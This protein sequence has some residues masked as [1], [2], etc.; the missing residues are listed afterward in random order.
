MDV[1]SLPEG[2]FIE[3]KS[4]YCYQA[5]KVRNIIEFII[6]IH[7]KTLIMLKLSSIGR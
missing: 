1:L 6:F 4:I 5:I 2:K 3:I 7:V